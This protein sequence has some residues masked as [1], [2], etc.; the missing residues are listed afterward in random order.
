MIAFDAP[1][2]LDEIK[3]A[4]RAKGLKQVDLANALGLSNPNKISLSLAGKRQFKAREMDMIRALLAPAPAPIVAGAAVREVPVIGSVAAGNWREAIQQSRDTIFMKAS[5]TPPNAV[6]LDVDG[7]SMDLV[8]RDAKTV[9]FDPDDKSLY[10]DKYYVIMNEDGETT[11][12]QFKSDPARLVPCS[13]N[14]LHKELVIG[15]GS[16]QIVGRVIAYHGRL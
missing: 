15:Q 2:T 12:K 5:D 3:E 8:I 7:D 4:M 11:F 6:A 10:P 16:F 13:S 1:M 14:P 9:V